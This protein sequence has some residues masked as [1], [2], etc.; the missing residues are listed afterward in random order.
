MVFDMEVERTVS[1]DGRVDVTQLEKRGPLPLHQRY[2]ARAAGGKLRLVPL[3]D[4]EVD[5]QAVVF[6]IGRT[7]TGG[8]SCTWLYLNGGSGRGGRPSAQQSRRARALLAEVGIS[9]R[10]PGRK[11]T[12][13]LG[14]GGLVVTRR[15]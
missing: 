9:R 3:D 5:P 13:R 8:R 6:R 11:V 15:A 7:E 2:E 10:G 14:P 12:V 1:A 4:P